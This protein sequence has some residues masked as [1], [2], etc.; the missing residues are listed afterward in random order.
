MILVREY[1]NMRMMACDRYS[2]LAFSVF[3]GTCVG[4]YNQRYFVVFCFYC[5]IASM[6]GLYVNFYYLMIVYS[7]TESSL[8]NFCPPVTLVR[9]LFGLVSSD[10]L[11]H[12][13][14]TYLCAITAMGVGGIFVSQFVLVVLGCTTYE[15]W[16]MERIFRRCSVSHFKSVFGHLWW[17]NFIVPLPCLQQPGNGIDWGDPKCV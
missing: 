1:W 6:Y 17:L 14:L 4:F 3:S 9:W 15:F 10:M 11:Y 12:V 8:W 5:T 2:N 13:A 7:Y 16:R